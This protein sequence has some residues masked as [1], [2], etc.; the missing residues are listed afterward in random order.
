MLWMDIIPNRVEGTISNSRGE[1]IKRIL[2]MFGMEQAKAID[3]AW[4]A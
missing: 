2:E 1:Q 3:R 4:V